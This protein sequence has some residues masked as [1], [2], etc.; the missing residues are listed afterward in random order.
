[1]TAKEIFTTI[2]ETNH[3]GDEDSFSGTG[4]NLEQT[5]VL[6][7]KLPH[8][9]LNHTVLD[10]P[11]GDFFWMR[12]VVDTVHIK[13]TGADIVEELIES[14]K[15]KYNRDFRVLDIL[16][17]Q[18]PKVDIIFCRDCLV[19]FSFEEIKQA[20]QNMKGSGSTYLLTTSFPNH[21]NAD[22]VMGE[23]RPVNLEKEPFNLGSPF[24]T[25]NEGCTENDG[26]FR[27]KSVCMWDL[28]AIKI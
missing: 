19:H 6:R 17:D 16:T 2:Y 12:S 24:L 1:M 15:K 5:K 26:I 27:D 23:W 10:I 22:V 9:F 18:L 7:K 4:S 28:Q 25:I 11:C 8:L 21:E 14:N 3:W 13:Y 20:I